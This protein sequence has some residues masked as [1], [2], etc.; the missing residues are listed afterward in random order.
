[1]SVSSWKYVGRLS[2]VVHTSLDDVL[3]FPAV[4][5]RFAASDRLAFPGDILY[6]QT[7]R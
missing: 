1:M 5:E 4:L 6:G 7:N 2:R 3:L